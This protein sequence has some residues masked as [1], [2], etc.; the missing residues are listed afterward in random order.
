MPC[1]LRGCHVPIVSGQAMS[2]E[3]QTRKESHARDHQHPGSYH[4]P[5]R[6][7]VL[8]C[9][10]SATRLYHSA[11]EFPSEQLRLMTPDHLRTRT[12]ASTRLQLATR[13]AS[14]EVR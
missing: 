9:M 8:F 14:H 2:A 10:N 7:S 6:P 5:R 13:V 11:E 1:I 3:P 12:A 4:V